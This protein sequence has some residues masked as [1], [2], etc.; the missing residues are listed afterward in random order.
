VRAHHT[1]DARVPFLLTGE[2]WR[3]PLASV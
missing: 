3:N 1:F 2:E